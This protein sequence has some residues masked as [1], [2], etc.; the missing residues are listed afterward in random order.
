MSILKLSDIEF[1]SEDRGKFRSFFFSPVIEAKKRQSTSGQFKK[2]KVSERAVRVSFIDGPLRDHTDIVLLR[3]K[4]GLSL[5]FGT[6]KSRRDIELL[7]YKLRFYEIYPVFVTK[8][9]MFSILETEYDNYILREYR[10]GKKQLQSYFKD[11]SDLDY[12]LQRLDQD[13][14]MGLKPYRATFSLKTNKTDE[15]E[16]HHHGILLVE[17]PTKHIEFF[18]ELL[19]EISE[20]SKHIFTQAS[21]AIFTSPTE[22]NLS[23]KKKVL[24]EFDKEIDTQNYFDKI[25][26]SLAPPPQGIRMERPIVV[27][28]DKREDWMITA[29]IVY[30]GEGAEGWINF[31]H[32]SLTITNN[33]ATVTTLK[34]DSYRAVQIYSAIDEGENIKEAT[35]IG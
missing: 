2:E 5:A 23:S 9:K 29:Y 34:G 28:M 1:L 12:I 18:N 3:N 17:N 8:S 19:D 16:I 6:V 25:V 15:F 35:V 22:S 26:A 10:A 11:H 32:Y 21:K 20:T 7:A 13:K 27:I 31:G 24:I 4:T 14:K 30:Q 33:Y